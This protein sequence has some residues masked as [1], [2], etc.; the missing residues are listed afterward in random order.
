MTDR[1]PDFTLILYHVYQYSIYSPS[2]VLYPDWTVRNRRAFNTTW[3]DVLL[4]KLSV[5]HT[6]NPHVNPLNLLEVHYH[7][8][9]VILLIPLVDLTELICSDT[10]LL[11]PPPPPSAPFINNNTP[12]VEFKS[13]HQGSICWEPH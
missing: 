11:T 2:S 6:E 8:R 9:Y 13:V 1:C 3:T 7:K 4:S 10:H 5:A 12:A